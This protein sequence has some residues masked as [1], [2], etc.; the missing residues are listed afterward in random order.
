MQ[1]V[2]E[3]SNPAELSGYA[4]TALADYEVNRFT[5]SRWLPSETID[6]LVYRFNKGGGGLVEAAQFRAY[7]ASSDS[8]VREGATRVTG[9]LPPIS[10]KI[11]VGE[12]ERIQERNAEVPES[13]KVFA[14][15]ENLTNAIAARV[16]L[17]RGDA[18]F[19]A[20][21]TI[22]ENGV[23]ASVDFGRNPAHSA[24]PE[25]MWTDTEESLPFD[26]LTAWVETYNETTGEVPAY[27]LMAEQMIRYLR[28]NAQLCRMSTTEAVPPV[29]LSTAAL[30]ALLKAHDLPQ[31]AAYD[32]R[33]V[34]QGVA[35]RIT[36]ADKI[37]LL[38]EP[39]SSVGLTLW[40]TPVEAQGVEMA[41]PS[42]DQPGILLAQYRSEDPQ[43]LWTRATAIVLPVVAAPDRTFVAQVA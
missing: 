19:N 25:I 36:P 12:Y 3:F 38:P 39:G 6:D 5:L 30:N 35:K 24:V 8:G 21:V 33:V 29:M 4:R 28:S 42:G 40:G 2:T 14:D 41:I 11:P 18:L 37:C 26:D 27:A 20:S 17:A 10:R 23:S 9:E 34:H 31:V 15:A 1:L 32:A 22:A 43:T 16:E 7:D 13:E